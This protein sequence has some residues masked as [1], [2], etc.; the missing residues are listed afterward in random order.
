MIANR[1]RSLLSNMF[2]L[3][4]RWGWRSYASNPV[5]HSQCNKDHGRERYL[6]HDE[7]ARLVKRLTRQNANASP[8]PKLLQQSAFLR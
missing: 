7:L 2:N 4:E 5:R 8:C 1:V 3:A 6:S